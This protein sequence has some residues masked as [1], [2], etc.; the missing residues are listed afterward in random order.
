MIG[1]PSPLHLAERAAAGALQQKQAQ[2]RERMAGL[3]QQADAQNAA[4]ALRRAP[5]TVAVRPSAQVAAVQREHIDGAALLSQVC[6]WLKRYL[7][8][9]SDS[10][11]WALTLWVA[12]SHCRDEKGE[13]VHETYPI[14]GFLSEEPGSGKTHALDLLALL[15][16]AVPGVLVEPSEAAVAAMVGKEHVT[17]LLDEGDVLFGSGKRKAAIRALLNSGYQK[18]KTWPRVRNGSVDHCPAYGA[19]AIAALSVMKNATGSSLEALMTRMVEFEMCKPPA[20]VVICKLR[21]VLGVHPDTGPITGRHA[22]ERLNARLAAWAAQERDA[23]AGTI[24]GMPEGVRLRDEDK[25]L[26]LLAV[27]ARAEVNRQDREDEAARDQGDNW[28]DLAWAACVDMS[29]YGG[30]PDVTEPELEDGEPG[31]RAAAVDDVLDGLAPEPAAILTHTHHSYGEAPAEA[32]EGSYVA[33]GEET[34][35]GRHPEPFALRGPFTTPE[36]AIRACEA[37]AGHT[38]VIVQDG[39]SWRGDT[40]KDDGTILAYCVTGEHQQ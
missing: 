3:R 37:D 39:D 10:K 24:P 4:N 38:L 26:P 17:L 32:P 33:G 27:A 23:I 36:E 6:A 1:V 29:L 31:S 34:R 12:G 5:G 8:L 9:D 18:G 16:P 28:A 20:G 21:E 14:A 25:W 40:T 7:Y 30:V 13:L 15:C 19:K 22:G 11:Y 35:P 2:Q